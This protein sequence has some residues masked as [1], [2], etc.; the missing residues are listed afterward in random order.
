MAPQLWARVSVLLI[1][2]VALGFI[3]S[4]AGL[5][6]MRSSE[7]DAASSL[8][9]SMNDDMELSESSVDQA[10]QESTT[11]PDATSAPATGGKVGDCR[12]TVALGDE[13]VQA[14]A[15]S[16]ANWRAHYGAQLA[17]DRGEIDGEEAKRRWAESK[18]PA[19]DDLAAYNDATTA[20]TEHGGCDDLDADTVG[21]DVQAEASACQ[22][23]ARE[24]ADVLAAAERSTQDWRG[25]L[26]MMARKD[27]YPIEEYLKI[28]TETVARAPGPM[29]D[30][31]DAVDGLSDAPPCGTGDD[32]ASGDLVPRT[33]AALARPSATLAGLSPGAVGSCVLASRQF[34]A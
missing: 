22:K 1:G 15:T 19:V 18:A 21:A 27:E 32:A 16:L 5:A 7:P 26:D 17:F 31:L 2:G 28:W 6:L 10:E 3:A 14:A 25:H 13:A 8:A 34:V 11:P 30:F 29:R 33:V 20:F 4:F 23:R 12:N 9:A 24:I